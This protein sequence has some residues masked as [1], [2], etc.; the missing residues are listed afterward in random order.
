MSKD[1]SGELLCRAGAALLCS[2]LSYRAH[3]ETWWRGHL[4]RFSEKPSPQH[5]EGLRLLVWNNL[6][7][8][9]KEPFCTKDS[10]EP[11]LVAVMFVPLKPFF[12]EVK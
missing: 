9:H 7:L 11:F 6:E 3:R 1:S 12:S 2:L 10:H 8:I 5:H 4:C